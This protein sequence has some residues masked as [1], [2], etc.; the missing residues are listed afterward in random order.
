MDSQLLS[1]AA[2]SPA[3]AA[4]VRIQSGLRNLSKY[5]DLNL[6]LSPSPSLSLNLNPSL[7]PSLNTTPNRSA[8]P[9]IVNTCHWKSES[10]S[11]V[12]SSTG[13]ISIHASMSAHVKG[14]YVSSPTMSVL[15]TS[16]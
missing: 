16:R 12:V 10:I 1:I 5:L 4:I 6:A 8:P 15:K 3:A 14:G 11:F 2:H 7:S 13:P 9:P